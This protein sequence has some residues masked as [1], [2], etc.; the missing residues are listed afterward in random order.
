MTEPDAKAD[1]AASAATIPEIPDDAVE[2]MLRMLITYQDRSTIK[3]IIAAPSSR[4][5]IAPDQIDAAM[6]EARRRL[7]VAADY[8]RDEEVAKAV[9]RLDDLY[10]KA[11]TTPDDNGRVDVRAAMGAQHQKNRLLGLYRSIYAPPVGEESTPDTTDTDAD[12]PPTAHPRAAAQPVAYDELID[13]IDAHLEPLALA[14]TINDT[15]V[16]VIR[17]AAEEI[18]SLR[19]RLARPKKKK[20][21]KKKA[22]KKPRRRAAESAEKKRKPTL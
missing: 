13:A 18:E 1:A 6:A 3:A 5:N 21:A 16:D 11:A 12:G 4:I 20:A 7:T 14:E 10:E 8:H 19:R 15:D 22:K 9:A 17:R 2:A